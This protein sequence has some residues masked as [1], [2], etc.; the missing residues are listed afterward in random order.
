MPKEIYLVKVGMSMTEGMVAEWFIPDGGEVKKGELVY[1]LE[2]EKVNLDVDAEYDGIVKHL[3]DVGIT[4]A[5]GDV[6]GYIFEPGEDIPA[7]LG[8][9]E[10]AP[11][12]DAKPAPAAETAPA[13]P[14]AAPD[15]AAAPAPAASTPAAAPSDGRIKSSPAARRLAK[16]LG[17]DYTRVVGRGPGGRIVE[18]DVQAAAT[19]GVAAAPVAASPIAA[20]GPEPKASPLAK[21]IAAARGIDLRAVRGTGPGGRIVQSDVESAAPAAKAASPSAA[22]ADAPKPGEVIPV[23]GMRKTIASRMHHSLMESAQ[24]TMDMEVL[25]DDAVKMRTGLVEEW[26]AEG[27]K[28]TYTDLVIKACAK[29]LQNHPLMNSQFQGTEIVVQNEINVGMAVALPEGLVVPVIRHVDQ[30]GLKDLARESSRLAVAARDGNL[31]LDDYAGGTFTVSA[32]G[33]Y[34]VDSFT[35]IINEPQVGI[36]GVN[37]LYDGVEWDG[38]RPIRTKKMNL[39]LTW[40]HRTLDG[41]PAAEYLVTVKELLEAPFRLLV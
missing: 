34:G 11:A 41:A 27:V 13:T 20:S 30:L 4:L 28:P 33:M 35:P 21:R 36:M 8:G 2:T 3:V 31:G 22:P 7:D 40:D 29:A 24:L 26:A 6:V 23:K 19:S 25:M 16:E 32:L 9:V 12:V 38:D 39:S 17:V 14:T 1:A 5:P 37:R 18:A 10:A 15:P